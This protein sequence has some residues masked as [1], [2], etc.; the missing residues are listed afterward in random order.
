LTYAGAAVIMTVSRPIA[1]IELNRPH[2]PDHAVAHMASTE[3]PHCSGFRIHSAGERLTEMLH[4]PCLETAHR[5]VLARQTATCVTA[6][7]AVNAEV[8][9]EDAYVVASCFEAGWS[10][11]G[12]QTNALEIRNHPRDS[13]PTMPARKNGNG[14]GR[15]LSRRVAHHNRRCHAPQSAA[16]MT[17]ACRGKSLSVRTRCTSSSRSRHRSE[18]TVIS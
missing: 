16:N 12:R 14:H 18:R 5:F 15:R 13:T 6:S 1:H 2:E 7:S 17:S 4:Q 10:K 9:L 8:T 11:G 3:V